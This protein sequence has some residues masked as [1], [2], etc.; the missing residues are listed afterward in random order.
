MFWSAL[1]F[2]I[3]QVKLKHTDQLYSE[4]KC[5]F[6]NC[7]KL[8]NTVYSLFRCICTAHDIESDKRCK[9]N[10]KKSKLLNELIIKATSSQ[11]VNLIE[12]IEPI[13]LYAASLESTL[14]KKDYNFSLKNF[15][16]RLL[17]VMLSLITKLYS[18]ENLNK[19]NAH[20]I[21]NEIFL[22]LVFYT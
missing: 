3:F 12:R 14:N 21:I 22:Y 20:K 17:N 10:N 2:Q 5:N 11:D 9:T 6:L 13:N 4:T 1:L 19:K 16:S 7:M 15:N 18:F 8:Y